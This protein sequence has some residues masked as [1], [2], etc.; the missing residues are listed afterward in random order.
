MHTLQYLSNFQIVYLCS[1]FELGV[2]Y[3]YV[4][5]ATSILTFHSTLSARAIIN[6]YIFYNSVAVHKQLGFIHPIE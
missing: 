6:L 4:L 2:Q 1:S 3:V 5:I